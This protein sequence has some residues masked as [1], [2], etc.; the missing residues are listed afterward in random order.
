MT[1]RTFFR[2]RFPIAAALPFETSHGQV[3]VC[4]LSEG[5]LRILCDTESGLHVGQTVQGTIVLSSGERID[6]KGLA[7]RREKDELV[8]TQAEGVTFQHMMN[9]QRNLVH[10]FP[11]GIASTPPATD[12]S[13]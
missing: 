4:E 11:K 3:S 7:V 12:P 1:D 6:V 2:L 10:R 8:I 5:G 9:E 13:N